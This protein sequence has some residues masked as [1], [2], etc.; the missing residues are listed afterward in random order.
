MQEYNLNALEKHNMDTAIIRTRLH[1]LREQRK[2]T[3]DDLARALGFKDRQTLS[4]IEL[5]ERKV[6]ADELVQ[7]ARFFKVPIEYFADP[8][9]LAGEG[10][11]SWRQ[12]TAST[13]Q[14]A[15]FETQAGKWIAAYRHLSRLKG[16]AVNSL[17][18]RVALNPKSTFEEAQ[19]EGEAIGRALK[20]GPIPALNLAQVIERDLDTLVLHVDTVKGI[21]GAA[22]RLGPLNAILINR[23]EHPARRNF[24]LAHELFH[25]LTWSDMPPRHIEG[26]KPAD[27]QEKRVEQLADNFAAALLMPRKT[28]TDLVRKSALP[29]EDSLVEWLVT[30]ATKLGVSAL[31]LKWRLVALDLIKKAVAERIGDDA[32]RAPRNEKIAAPPRFSARF[33]RVLAWA[34]DQ[35]H[36][37]ARR[38]ATLM[39]LTL[40]DLAAVFGEH[41]LPAPFDL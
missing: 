34:I 17:T 1:A 28:V 3:Q 4:A 21:S 25:L 29:D 36:L 27:A 38:A 18:R 20:L 6:T 31:A 32:F 14:L 5:G 9:E 39:G 33:A 22:C 10:R 19:A 2:V 26:G 23:H 8:F 7:A 12:T 35:G 41:D 30:N 13:K 40:D 24:D 16:D 15:L 11:F 37:S